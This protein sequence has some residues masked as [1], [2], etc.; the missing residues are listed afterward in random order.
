M[1]EWMWLLLGA[2]FVTTILFA[3]ARGK[4]LNEIERRLKRQE[5]GR[6]GI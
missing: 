4:R 6:T 5:E 2:S 1:P 3:I